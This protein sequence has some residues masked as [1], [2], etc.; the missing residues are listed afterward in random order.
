MRHTKANWPTGDSLK[1]T[2]ADLMFFSSHFIFLGH[3]RIHHIR[4]QASDMSVVT[5]I[6]MG[7][8]EEKPK[9]STVNGGLMKGFV[10]T[11]SRKG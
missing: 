8:K 5:N 1:K 3:G 4:S 10:N 7:K 11:I 9:T 6:V 2:E